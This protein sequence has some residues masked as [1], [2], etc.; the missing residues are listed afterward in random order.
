MQTIGLEEQQFIEALKEGG[1][2]VYGRKCNTTGEYPIDLDA[3]GE[4]ISTTQYTGG[5]EEYHYHNI[6]ELCSTTESYM[7]FLAKEK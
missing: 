7:A 1:N 3:S 4:P 6:N 5:A 2:Q